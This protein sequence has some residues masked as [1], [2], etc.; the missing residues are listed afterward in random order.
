[1]L[2]YT[3]HDGTFAT[4]RGC[5]VDDYVS[6]KKVQSVRLQRFVLLCVPLGCPK[7][8]RCSVAPVRTRHTLREVRSVAIT[9]H[10]GV[11]NIVSGMNTD[12]K[13]DI[14]TLNTKCV[15]VIDSLMITG[16]ISRSGLT[17]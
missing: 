16:E 15:T 3:G 8:V 9:R 17:T 6:V 2:L 5:G 1:M 7:N 11:G 13:S 4:I 12:C 10:A 14:S